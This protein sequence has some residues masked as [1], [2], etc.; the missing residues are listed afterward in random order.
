MLVHCTIP[1]R[2]DGRG[3]PSLE[4]DGKDSFNS[5]IRRA[6]IRYSK[7]HSSPSWLSLESGCKDD[8]SGS[9]Y[10]KTLRQLGQR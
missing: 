1:A 9:L 7:R 3:N 5:Q 10:A 4:V 6:L 8:G 2:A